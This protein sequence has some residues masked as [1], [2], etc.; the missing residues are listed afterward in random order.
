[1]TKNEQVIELLEKAIKIQEQAPS[2]YNVKGFI[3]QALALLKS[4]PKPAVSSDGGSEFTKALTQSIQ[5]MHA[6]METFIRLDEDK[7]KAIID[8]LDRLTAK[9]EKLKK[10]Q[11]DFGENCVV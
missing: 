8:A 11:E 2:I 1:M 9:N 3:N 10:E 4:V 7:A 6:K 5:K